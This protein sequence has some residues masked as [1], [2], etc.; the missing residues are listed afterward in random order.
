M[1][2]FIVQKPGQDIF[3]GDSGI[4]EIHDPWMMMEWPDLSLCEVP[5]WIDQGLERPAIEGNM[6]FSGNRR[7]VIIFI[8]PLSCDVFC[9]L[10]QQ[11]RLRADMHGF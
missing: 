8:F 1:T 9:V 4:L 3:C 2:L 10:L 7:V 6:C 5:V 11:K